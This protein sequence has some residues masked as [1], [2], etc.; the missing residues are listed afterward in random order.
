MWIANGEKYAVVALEVQLEGAMPP[1]KVATDLWC[2]TGARIEVPSEWRDWLGGIRADEVGG[3]NL[4]LVSKLVSAAPDILDGENQL[5]EKR[6]WRFYVGLLLSAVFSPSH[7][8]VLLTGAC[9]NGV[10]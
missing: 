9:H 3:S 2:F 10:V 8:P 6:V 1:E 4:L 5:L 7:R